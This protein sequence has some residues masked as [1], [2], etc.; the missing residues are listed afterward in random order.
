MRFNDDGAA[1]REKTRNFFEKNDNDGE[2]ER[3]KAGAK[4]AA[5]EKEGKE[6][7]A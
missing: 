5:V 3:G 1:L 6:K 2:A 7:S 4:E